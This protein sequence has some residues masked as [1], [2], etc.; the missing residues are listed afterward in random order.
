MQKQN[1]NIVR[2][3]FPPSE[4]KVDLTALTTPL[5]TNEDFRRIL[6]FFRNRN[7]THYLILKFLF[8]TGGSLPDLIYFQLGNLDINRSSITLVDRKR[9][10]FREIW[11]EPDFARELLRSA[12]HSSPECLLFPGRSGNREE[13][14]IQKILNVASSLISKEMNIPLLRDSLALYFFLQGVPL[15]EIQVFLGHRSV[16]STK[17]RISL[18]QESA[19]VTAM[20][21]FSRQ[22][23]KAA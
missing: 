14:S 4:L 15:H 12:T 3:P 13:R 11:I 17:H 5:F 2:F 21:H 23:G 19:E 6:S 1:Q 10:R 22:K 20:E 8:C 9:L 18:Y 7:H 16:K